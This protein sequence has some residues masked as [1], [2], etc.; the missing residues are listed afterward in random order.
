MNGMTTFVGEG[1]K[2]YC[3]TSHFI[4]SHIRTRENRSASSRQ[5][6]FIRPKWN[7]TISPYIFLFALNFAITIGRAYFFAVFPTPPSF[8]RLISSHAAQRKPICNFKW[9]FSDCFPHLGLFHRSLISRRSN[10]KRSGVRR[11]STL[12]WKSIW[13]IKVEPPAWKEGEKVLKGFVAHGKSATLKNGDTGSFRVEICFCR[14]WFVG[15]EL[16]LA[17]KYCVLN[18]GLLWKQ[19]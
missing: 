19:A 1:L 3:A 12:M 10:T 11:L 16:L 17:M 9:D 13:A 7:F 14:S 6:Q 2:Q 15:A 5:F 8:A 4:C 18:W